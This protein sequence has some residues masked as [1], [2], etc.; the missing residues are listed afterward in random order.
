[1]AVPGHIHSTMGTAGA[2]LSILMADEGGMKH[3][4]TVLHS[5]TPART[6]GALARNGCQ[7]SWK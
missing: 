5:Q 6:N 4:G 3:E 7:P 1:M 2:A